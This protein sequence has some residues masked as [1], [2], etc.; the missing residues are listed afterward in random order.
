MELGPIRS[1]IEGEEKCEENKINE[2][3]SEEK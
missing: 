1:N 2:K 3:K